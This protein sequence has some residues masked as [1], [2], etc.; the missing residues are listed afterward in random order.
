MGQ[1]PKIVVDTAE[2]FR[3]NHRREVAPRVNVR[4]A[5]ERSRAFLLS[6]PL[7]QTYASSSLS[8]GL[9]V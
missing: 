2:K 8:L 9:G 7:E 3:L 1:K 6:G 4:L 5:T